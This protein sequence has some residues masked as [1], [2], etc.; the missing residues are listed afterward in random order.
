MNNSP[1]RTIVLIPAFNAACYLEEL[2]V[3]VK[4]T[5]PPV[6]I[7]VI[8]DGSADDT[9][10]IAR[11]LNCNV[12]TNEKNRGKGY[13]LKRGF[14]Y[15][16]K[17]NY[18]YL[19]TIDADLQH[20]PEEMKAFMNYAGNGSIS[21]GTRELS[22]KKM[23]LP[24]WLSNNL[25]S[26]LVSIFGGKV[27]R[28]SQSGFRMFDL[29]TLKKMRAVSNR[30]DFESELLFQ[31]GLLDIEIN[32]VPISTIYNKERSSINQIGDTLRFVKQIWKRIML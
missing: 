32:E 28:D 26:L 17:K 3:R 8:N 6:D 18:D 5:I 23:P 31:A 22:M 16:L 2:V 10:N 9:G 27:I 24:R 19:I 15:S 4:N 29:K 1:A 21:I 20:L 25:T 7:L 30:F 11:S 12:L 13:S 14:A